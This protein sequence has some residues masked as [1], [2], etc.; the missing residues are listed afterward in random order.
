MCE[1]ERGFTFAVRDIVGQEHPPVSTLPEYSERHSL[2]RRTSR[3]RKY[4][5]TCQR[6]AAAALTSQAIG[7]TAKP[8]IQKCSVR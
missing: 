3:C 1:A 6:H 8:R 5:T 4:R 2:M 7:S